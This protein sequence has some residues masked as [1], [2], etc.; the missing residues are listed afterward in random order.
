M[1][2]DFNKLYVWIMSQNLSVD[3]SK[4]K[5]WKSRLIQNLIKKL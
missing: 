2:P 5:K 1:Y 3:G 4:W